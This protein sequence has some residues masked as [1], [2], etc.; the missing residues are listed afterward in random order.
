MSD[1]NNWAREWSDIRKHWRLD[2]NVV[3]LNHG[4]YGAV[5]NV[6]REAQN[7]LRDRIYANPSKFF[8][9][10][11]DQQLE[12]TREIVAKFCQADPQGLAF[13]R[14]ACEGVST[15]LGSLNLKAGDE[16][17]VTNHCYSAVL[18]AAK[19]YASRV[20]ASVRTV[21]VELTSDMN[22]IVNSIESAVSEKTRL[23]IIDQ[24]AS[25]TAMVFPINQIISSMR[26]LN[27]PVL[28]D[29]AHGPGM[30]PLNLNEMN[31]DFWVGNFHKWLCAPYGSAGLYVHNTWRDKIAPLVTATRFELAYPQSFG[32]LGTD[33]LS[34]ILSVPQA[35][36][37]LAGIGWERLYNYNYALAAYGANV[38]AES[39][40]TVPIKA[41][42]RAR[43]AV[44]LP[45][46]V[47]KDKASALALQA[48]IGD[49]L[50]TEVSISCPV[51]KRNDHGFVVL[52]AFCYNLPN[53]YERFGKELKQLLA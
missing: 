29:G 33:D 23:L 12:L 9:R 1:L 2:P 11:A 13:V 14:N 39:L 32:R 42:F 34:A 3:H 37:F 26:S 15:V 53:E 50:N 48:A 24:I 40:G 38:V 16:I 4:S 8:R 27:I 47:A 36:E 5:P 25:P 51:S 31:P 10:V 30:E 17:L 7:S 19:R 45:N 49:K 18:L 20:G 22:K 6:V 46:G 41:N 44:P 21:D 28:V 35:I 43:V 52:S